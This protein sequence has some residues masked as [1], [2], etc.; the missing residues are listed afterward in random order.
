[1]LFE[2]K[3]VKFGLHREKIGCSL[4]G[5]AGRFNHTLECV[6][7]SLEAAVFLTRHFCLSMGILPLLACHRNQLFK[8]VPSRTVAPKHKQAAEVPV[9]LSSTQMANSVAPG[10]GP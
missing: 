6:C 7:F 2:V 10:L 8:V 1:M 9:E 4:Y 5:R 3:T